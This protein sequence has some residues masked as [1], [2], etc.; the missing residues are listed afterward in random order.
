M[1]TVAPLKYGQLWDRGHILFREG[2]TAEE[3]LDKFNGKMTAMGC[4]LHLEYAR[5]R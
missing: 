3:V 4:R 5:A 2:D 1:L